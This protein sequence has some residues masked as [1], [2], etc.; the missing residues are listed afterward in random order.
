MGSFKEL[1]PES[2]PGLNI[3]FSLKSSITY[4][5]EDLGARVELVL[6][7]FEEEVVLSSGGGS[8]DAVVEQ[9]D[10]IVGFGHRGLPQSAEDAGPGRRRLRG[11][12][13]AVHTTLERGEEARVLEGVSG[14]ADGLTHGGLT[15]EGYRSEGGFSDTL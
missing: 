15:M 3:N 9:L 4:L 14:F 13:W 12:G 7:V 1:R 6:G 5:S 11:W 2:S 8:A 10:E